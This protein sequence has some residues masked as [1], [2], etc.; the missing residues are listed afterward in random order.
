MGVSRLRRPDRNFTRI[1][2]CYDCRLGPGHLGVSVV[3]ASS[4]C[5]RAILE[6]THRLP[7]EQAR[8]DRQDKL[9]AQRHA[10]E[11]WASHENLPGLG[12]VWRRR[13]IPRPV[14]CQIRVC[15]GAVV[16]TSKGASRPAQS[17]LHYR[18]QVPLNPDR[19]PSHR[20]CPQS[21]ILHPGCY[22]L[23]WI[24]R[25]LWLSVQRQGHV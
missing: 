4:P 12:Y 15:Q 2:R 23:P 1:D 16:P 18:A 22:Q 19:F 20:L 11:I 14:R 17:F 5:P 13:H 9:R 10:K 8:G 6:L 3:V 21:A 25:G 7:P 24:R